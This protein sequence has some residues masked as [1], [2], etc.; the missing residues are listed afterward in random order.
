MSAKQV[1]FLPQIVYLFSCKHIR[2]VKF[3]KLQMNINMND[4]LKF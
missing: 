2:K 3:K 4:R 1:V